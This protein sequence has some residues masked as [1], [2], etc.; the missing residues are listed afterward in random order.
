MPPWVAWSM[1]T[2]ISTMV[3]CNKRE[4]RHNETK[5]ATKSP[6]FIPSH[7]NSTKPIDSFASVAQTALFP[8][9]IPSPLPFVPGTCVSSDFNLDVF[10]FVDTIV[11]FGFCGCGFLLVLGD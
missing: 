5:T 3:W 10:G 11:V 4:K 2:K 1:S 6:P 9:V 8:Q 7:R